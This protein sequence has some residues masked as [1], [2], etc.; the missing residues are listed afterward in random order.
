M[1]IVEKA[2]IFVEKL[3][4]DQLSPSFLYHNYNHTQDVVNR[5]ELLANSENLSN[6]DREA[7]LVAA[8]FHDT[9][10]VE[11]APGH[12]ERSA[13]IAEGF[14]RAENQSEDFIQKVKAIIL[15]TKYGA[16]VST[17]AEGIIQDADFG[18]VAATDY[19]TSCE[20]LRKEWE[21]TQKKYISDEQWCDENIKFF[22]SLHQF[23]TAY[24]RENWEPIKQKNLKRIEN[25]YEKDLAVVDEKKEDK[26]KK[27]K[28]KDEK[29][30]EK[31]EPKADRSVDTMFRVTLNNHTRLSDIADSKANIL[32]SVNAIIISIALSTLL[33]KLDSAKNAHLVWP[34]FIMLFFSVIT[35]I[36]AILSTKPNVT[37]ANFT[38]EDIKNRKVNLL[39]F[40]NFYKMN[41]DDFEPAIRDMMDDRQYL[42][43]SM[44]RDLYY[45]G[46]VLN[47][48]YRL[49]SITYKIFMFEIIA[50]VLAFAYAFWSI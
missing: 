38:Q 46:V 39:F 24:A 18:H 41:L 25:A 32:L 30:K 9:G 14:L 23:N 26:K 2:R 11:G 20:H 6:E 47:R 19:F 31:A 45:L 8:W 10:Y 29:E 42:Y 16:A 48:K 33:P 4:K 17:I 36:F 5:S 3:L 50:S 35:I 49:L 22:K 1:T 13:T 43:D 27:K 44:I 15:A 40:G 37:T 34:T 28:D 21:L 7:L 12:E